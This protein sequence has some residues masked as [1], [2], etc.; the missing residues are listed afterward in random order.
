M[1]NPARNVLYCLL[2]LLASAALIRLGTGREAEVGEHWT[3]IAPLFL[4]VAIAPFALVIAIFA[5]V[6][7]L[8]TFLLARRT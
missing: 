2:A 4:G 6:L 8:A 7:A 5:A 1:R 3:S